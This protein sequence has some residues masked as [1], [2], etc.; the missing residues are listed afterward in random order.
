ME[1]RGPGMAEF[2]SWVS[3]RVVHRASGGRGRGWSRER[4]YVGGG[5]R[6]SV[7]GELQDHV[8][9]SGLQLCTSVAGGGEVVVGIVMGP[10]PCGVVNGRASDLLFLKEMWLIK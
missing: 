4:K 2:S 3:V 10:W 1:L 9:V 5:E 7:W 8:A 6:L